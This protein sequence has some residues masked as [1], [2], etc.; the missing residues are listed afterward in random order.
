M[1]PES[2]L[3]AKTEALPQNVTQTVRSFEINFT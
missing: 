1:F 3:Q 2:V